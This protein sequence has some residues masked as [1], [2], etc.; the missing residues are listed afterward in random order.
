M[1]SMNNICKILALQKNKDSSSSED[2][3]LTTSKPTEIDYNIT[4][5]VFSTVTAD[6]TELLTDAI[7]A[8]IST[9][10]YTE[11]AVNLTTSEFADDFYTTDD[12][13]S[14]NVSMSFNETFVDQFTLTPSNSSAGKDARRK[15]TI[16]IRIS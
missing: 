6:T 7:S 12:W 4:S 3:V 9:T 13:T 10:S 15:L 16:F 14:A 11:K 1:D 2:T 5:D 8:A